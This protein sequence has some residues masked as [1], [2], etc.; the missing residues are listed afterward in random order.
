MFNDPKRQQGDQLL[1][2][3]LCATWQV[4]HRPYVGVVENSNLPCAFSIDADRILFCGTLKYVGVI[5]PLTSSQLLQ[6]H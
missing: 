4:L 2:I 6:T 1:L 5:Q 3:E